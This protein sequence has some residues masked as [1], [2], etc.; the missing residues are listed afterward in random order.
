MG[1]EKTESACVDECF[2]KVFERNRKVRQL[3]GALVTRKVFCF[4]F[5]QYD[6][7]SNPLMGTRL[8]MKE[9]KEKTKE[10]KFLGSGGDSM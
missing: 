10:S 4:F 1:D 7:G 2:E 6:D 9:R 3:E 5:F 8:M